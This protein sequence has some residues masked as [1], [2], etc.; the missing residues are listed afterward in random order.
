MI[1]SIRGYNLEKVKKYGKI[2]S[3]SCWKIV[4]LIKMVKTEV[5]AKKPSAWLGITRTKIEFHKIASC[6]L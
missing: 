5:Q 2:K 3:S 1:F 4:V 6:K